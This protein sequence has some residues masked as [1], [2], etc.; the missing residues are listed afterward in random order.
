MTSSKSNKTYTYA[1]GRRRE[2]IAN[3]K[4]FKGKGDSLINKLS[5]DKYFPLSSQKII[6]NRPFVTTGTLDKYYFEARTSGGGKIGQLN[7][8]TLAISRALKIINETYGPLLRDAGLL[9]VDARVRQRRMVG[10]GG[11]SRRQ[12]QSPKR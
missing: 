10:M 8:I 1:I 6:Y 4:L 2:A 9:T 3:I 11:K 7:A 5:V 12:R